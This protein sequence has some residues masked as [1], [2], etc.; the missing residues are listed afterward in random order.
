MGVRTGL[1]VGLA[2][3]GLTAL[4]PAAAHAEE[5]TRTGTIGATTLDNVGCRRTP[6]AS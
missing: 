1:S 6:R 3:A 4:V 5:R 2:V